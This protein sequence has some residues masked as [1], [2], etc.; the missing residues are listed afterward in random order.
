[1]S[2]FVLTLPSNSFM[3]HFPHNTA[4]RY[5]TKLVETLELEGAWEVGLLEIA[6][7]S[8]IENV[9]EDQ[10][11]YTIFFKPGNSYAIVRVPAG[12]YKKG[13]LLVDALHDAQRKQLRKIGVMAD[14][15]PLK[16]TFRP[17]FASRMGMRVELSDDVSS[18]EFSPDLAGI[19][20]FDADVKYSGHEPIWGQRAVDMYGSLGLLYVYCDLAEYVLVGDTKAPVLRI[21]DRPSDIKGIEHRIMNPVQYVPLQKKCFDTVTVSIMLDSGTPVPFL[22]GKTVVVLEFRRAMQ[23]FFDI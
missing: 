3:D 9:S 16:V 22:A 19:L 15:A 11:Y 23:L 18:F 12:L 8:S 21:V 2:R 20:G 5:T 7:P 10:C 1:M 13:N 4:A 14:G 17:P 6:S